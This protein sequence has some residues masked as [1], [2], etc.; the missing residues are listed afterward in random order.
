MDTYQ[1]PGTGL[2]VGDKALSNTSYR[3]VFVEIIF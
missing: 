3:P 2:G 1:A